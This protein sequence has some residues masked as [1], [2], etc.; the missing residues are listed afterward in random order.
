MALSHAPV[1]LLPVGG[2]AAS[3]GHSFLCRVVTA[4]IPAVAYSFPS[5][6]SFYICVQLYHYFFSLKK[7]RNSCLTDNQIN[8]A[9]L[10][11]GATEGTIAV[12]ARDG[13]FRWGTRLLEVL[14][15]TMLEHTGSP[16]QLWNVE[17][18]SC[19]AFW[20]RQ[21]NEGWHSVPRIIHE[22]N[23]FRTP[24]RGQFKWKTTIVQ[25]WLLSFF[26]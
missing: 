13:N 24:S 6:P 3:R 11:T 15:H 18:S 8:P 22:F 14:E 19:W 26:F 23:A 12:Q 16:R 25:C 21:K 1:L 10:A 2:L 5:L 9:S 20:G 4:P 17:N 7:Q